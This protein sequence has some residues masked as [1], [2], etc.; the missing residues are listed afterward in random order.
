MKFL[1]SLLCVLVANP[2]HAED[3]NVAAASDLNFAIKEIIQRFE[4]NTGNKVRLTLGSSG[5]FYALIV[6]G[7]PFDVFLSADVNY[8]KQLEQRGLAVAGSTFI[9]GIGGISLW[10]SRNSIIKVDSLGMRSLLEPSGRKIAIANPEHAPYGRAA[11]A[12][13][14]NAKVYD[15]V[16]SKLV[17]GESVSQ[18]AQFVQTGA[19]D[20]GIIALSIA[21]SEPMLRTGKYWTIPRNMYPPLE[22]GAVLLKRGGSGAKAFYEWLRGA[23]S[24]RILQKYGFGGLE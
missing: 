19:A 8:P 6:N 3:I 7:A 23:E 24:K 22:Q 13:M 14:Q 11:V 1:L 17:F 5:N 9:Y 20:I 18:A 15:V 2:L 21:M 10:V 16:K 12:A 4:H